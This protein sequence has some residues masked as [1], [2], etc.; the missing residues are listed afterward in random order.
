MATTYAFPMNAS[1]GHEHHGFGHAR[2]HNRKNTVE[3]LP[4]QPLSSN[5]GLGGALKREPAN[6]HLQSP[7]HHTHSHSVPHKPLTGASHHRFHS[8][9]QLS[10]QEFASSKPLGNN[11]DI[12]DPWIVT[13]TEQ[14]GNDRCFSYDIMTRSHD[15]HSG[16]NSSGGSARWVITAG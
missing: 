2:S 7:I 3:R 9:A 5:G 16:Q 1:A 12:A 6:S 8:N 13:P 10:S 15:S 4:L 11:K 14:P